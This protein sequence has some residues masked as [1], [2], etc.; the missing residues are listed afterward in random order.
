MERKIP[1]H[2][3]QQAHYFEP[4]EE[5]S[6]VSHFTVQKSGILCNAKFLINIIKHT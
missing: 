2:L 3:P 6:R 5:Y 1:E 4:T